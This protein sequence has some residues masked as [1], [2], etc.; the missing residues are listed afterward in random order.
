MDHSPY[1]QRPTR[2]SDVEYDD[3]P[4]ASFRGNTRPR[5]RLVDDE[6]LARRYEHY[7]EFAPV[8]AT[9]LRSRILTSIIA[10]PFF[11]A[12]VTWM[13]GAALGFE[14]TPAQVPIAAIYGFILGYYRP[15]MTLMGLLT[16]GAAVFMQWLAGTLVLSFTGL[17]LVE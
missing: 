8:V 9:R 14:T 4:A 6:T 17:E 15:S 5:P 16:L 3:I 1:R 13:G 11:N 7:G 10:W 12:A 2:I